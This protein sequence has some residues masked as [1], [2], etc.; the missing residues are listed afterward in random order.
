MLLLCEGSIHSSEFRPLPRKRLTVCYWG[1]QVSNSIRL[2]A[3]LSVGG[4]Q[5]NSLEP[6]LVPASGG[7]LLARQPG[8]VL[9]LIAFESFVFLVWRL[10]AG[11]LFHDLTTAVLT[12][13]DDSSAS[14]VKH[15]RGQLI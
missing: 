12:T 9:C 5:N 10:Y 15:L 4:E 3:F 8:L 13:V 6:N 11:H 14:R 7:F 1:A 2:I